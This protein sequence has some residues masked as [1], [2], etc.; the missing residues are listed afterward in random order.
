[1]MDSASLSDL[2]SETLVLASLGEVLALL[3]AGDIASAKVLLE[4]TREHVAI[5]AAANSTKH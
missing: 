1:M 4:A 3:E 2:T 5:A